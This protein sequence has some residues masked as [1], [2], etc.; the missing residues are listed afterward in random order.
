MQE[1]MRVCSA[2]QLTRGVASNKGAATLLQVVKHSTMLNCFETASQ[3][4]AVMGQCVK[5][6]QMYSS[7]NLSA[8]PTLQ[9][10]VPMGN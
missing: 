4:Q 10:G 1:S 7:W 9:D 8:A 2:R 5:A 3:M 6:T